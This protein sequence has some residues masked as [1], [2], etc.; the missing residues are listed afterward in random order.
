MDAA[1]RRF[2]WVALVEGISYLVLL[3]VAMPLKYGLGWPLGVKVV[4]AAHGVLFVAYFLTLI[5]AAVARDWGWRRAAVAGLASLIPGATF[6]L[7]RRLRPG[8]AWA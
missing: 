5:Q 4:G 8:G 2:R 6:W 3:G 1:A 7:D